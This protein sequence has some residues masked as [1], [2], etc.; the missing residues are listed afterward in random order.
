M[1]TYD[2]IYEHAEALAEESE[3]TTEEMIE[4]LLD[5]YDPYITE[6]DAREMVNEILL[7]LGYT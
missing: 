3:L 5:N 6:V 2:T 1:I 7:K 4:R